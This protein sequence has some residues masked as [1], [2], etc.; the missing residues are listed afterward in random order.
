[1]ARFLKKAKDLQD[2]PE[3]DHDNPKHSEGGHD[4]SNWLVSY[5][6]MMTLL[7]AFFIM[8]FSLSSLNKSEFE[9]VRKEV[10]EQLGGIYEQ[11]NKKLHRA[12]SQVLEDSELQKN[13]TVSSD[14]YG[15]TISFQTHVFFE[16][17]TALLDPQGRKLVHRLMDR[18]LSDDMEE[19]SK[20]RIMV[21]GHTDSQPL[22]SGE[23]PSNWELS[24]A[25][26]ASVLRLFV[27]RG[28]N[29]DRMMAIGFADSRPAR[30]DRTPA[31]EWD[32][33]GLEANRRV[34]IRLL[35]P[36]AEFFPWDRAESSQ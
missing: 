17:M 21:E 10:V 35:H 12:I 29:P 9:K 14:P 6:D 30:P 19:Y 3:S 1:M 33:Q 32:E 25:R 11:P 16:P 22:V 34:L 24:S 31:G 27:D 4:E 8:M 18:I 20:Y 5:A 15:V 2:H 28:F 36:E 26:A 23:F 7:C 13:V